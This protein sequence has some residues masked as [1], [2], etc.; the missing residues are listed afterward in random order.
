MNHQRLS[1]VHLMRRKNTANRTLLNRV[2]R[3]H[4]VVLCPE[5]RVYVNSHIPSCL[6]HWPRLSPATRENGCAAFREFHQF[7]QAHKDSRGVLEVRDVR[8]P[9]S[10]PRCG[11]RGGFQCF[12]I[13]DH[14]NS[15]IRVI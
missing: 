4:C 11:K 6:P 7:I 14:I 3:G 1:L 10:T 12:W 9:P 15:N 8:K 13:F 2:D 5:N